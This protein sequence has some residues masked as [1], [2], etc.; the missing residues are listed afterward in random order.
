VSDVVHLLAELIEN[1]TLY[2]P[3]DTQVQ[4]SA[5]ELSSGGVL[6]EVTDKGIGVSEARLAEMNWRLDNPPTMDVSVSRHM[7]L[8]A[9]ARLAERHRVRVRLRPAS[10][11]GLTA[12]VWLPDSVIERTNRA[13]YGGTGGWQPPVG[14]PVPPQPVGASQG[15]FQARRIP[16]QFTGGQVG[17]PQQSQLGAPQPSQLGAPQPSQP[18]QP[19]Y[20]RHSLGARSVADESYQDSYAAD[21]SDTTMAAPAQN[22]H[23]GATLPGIGAGTG[24]GAAQAA[25]QVPTSNW[26]R[27]RRTPPGSGT[28]AS[29]TPGGGAGTGNGG[30]GNGG[31]G[32]GGVG[33][34]GARPFVTAGQPGGGQPGG[35]YSGGGAGQPGSG[36]G[37]PGGGSTGGPG[38]AGTG[39][40]PAGRNPRD[41]VAEPTRGEETAAGL[42]L[43]VP[44][45]NLIPGSAAGAAPGG[46]NGRGT[47]GTD[48]SQEA[49]PPSGS[50][51]QRSPDMARSRLSGFQRG[52]RRAEGQGPRTGEGTDR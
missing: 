21:R 6:I 50:L 30:L 33:D 8:F 27:S 48:S 12:L 43:R 37:A 9:V 15:G 7:G 52:S 18:S 47:R 23:D 16:G 34:A 41:I 2:S 20:G 46:G 17:A 4:V 38:D 44:K 11:Q 45:A 35:S 5:Q 3:K 51:P 29:R 24:A 36:W 42:P 26:F 19:S 22:G 49:Q 14:Q 32:N 10:P 1:A 40:W 28:G 31:A 39:S 13:V 25:S